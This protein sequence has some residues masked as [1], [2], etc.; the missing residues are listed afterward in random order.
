MKKKLLSG[1]AMLLMSSFLFS[2]GTVTASAASPEAEGE[3]EYSLGEGRA[4][5][6]AISDVQKNE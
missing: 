5:R 6:A 3:A 4:G 1:V 2:F